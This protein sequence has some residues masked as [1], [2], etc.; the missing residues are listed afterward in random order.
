MEDLEAFILPASLIFYYVYLYM[1]K[2]KRDEMTG[3]LNRFTYVMDIKRASQYGKGCGIIFVDMND[4]KEI[5][6]SLGHAEG[7]RA[8]RSLVDYFKTNLPR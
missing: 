2:T 7:N 5:N 8:I 1:M 4:L 3:A 6:N